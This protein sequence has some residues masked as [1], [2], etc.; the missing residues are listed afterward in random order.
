MRALPALV[1]LAAG[2]VSLAPAAEPQHRETTADQVSVIVAYLYNFGKFVEWPAGSFA[3]PSSP[4]RFCVYGEDPLGGAMD[5]LARRRLQ[6]RPLDIERLRRG[7]PFS[8]CHVLYVSRSE[9]FNIRP[10]IAKSATLPLLTVSD[11][12][13]FAA[14]GGVI[15][16]VE[17]D[18]KVRFEVNA[19]AA[20]AAR[21]Q[22]SSQLLKLAKRVI[23]GG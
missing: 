6:G 22:V 18:S 15:G 17:M 19:G 3:A 5:G 23:G 1:I 8:D 14:S 2:L 13:G 4:V 16:L 21:L 7:Q 12:E 10:L 20:R 9:E 11:I